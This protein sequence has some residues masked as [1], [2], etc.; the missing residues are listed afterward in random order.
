MVLANLGGSPLPQMV[1][2]HAADRLLGLPTIDWSGEELAK[3]AKNK[4][5]TKE[6]KTKKDTVRRPG[7]VPSHKLAEYTGE[8]EHPGYG[9]IRIELA[10]GKLNF[11][12]NS[13]AAPLEHWHFEV[14]A[15]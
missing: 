15:P 6:A 1:T 3:K 10:D 5:A 8:Y 14:F 4:A 9:V 12:Y 13:I 7:T 11:T 2:R